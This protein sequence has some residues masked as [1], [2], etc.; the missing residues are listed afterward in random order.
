M[1]PPLLAHQ[2]DGVID[3]EGRFVGPLAGEGV[4]DIGEGDDAS[5]DGDGFA[6]QAVGIAGP[7]PSFV[8]GERDQATEPEQLGVRSGEDLAADRRVLPHLVP[9]LGG[10]LS[11]LAQDLVG[12][13]DLADVVHGAGDPDELGPRR[14]PCRT[15]R[16]ATRRSGSSG[17]RCAPVAGSRNS[18]AWARRRMASSCDARKAFSARDRLLDRGHEVLG[19]FRHQELQVLAV[20]A[21]LDFEFRGGAGRCPPR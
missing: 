8:V 2:C 10:E 9:F 15:A 14:S 5:L 16:P 21:V 11:G 20:G 3:L 6:D 19:P 4:E 17:S 18:T 13:G 1:T 12:H 7:V